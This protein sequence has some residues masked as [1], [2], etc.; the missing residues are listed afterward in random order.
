MVNGLHPMEIATNAEVRNQFINLYNEIWKNEMGEA[1]YENEVLFFQE[2]IANTISQI[3]SSIL[4]SNRQKTDAQAYEEAIAKIDRFSVYVAFR[5]ICFTDLS[6]EPGANALAYIMS[7]IYKAIGANGNLQWKYRII[8]CVSGYGELIARK[9]AGQIKYVDNPVVVYANDEFRVID[10]NGK[11]SI[12][13]SMVLPHDG[14]EIIACYM[15]ITRGDDS[16]DYSVLTKEDW[17]RLLMFSDKQNRSKDDKRALGEAANAL[18]TSNGGQIDKG[19][20]IA[21]CVKHGFKLF[22][23][24][25]IGRNAIMG[26]DNEIAENII[27]NSDEVIEPWND[28][29]TTCQPK[30]TVVSGN[31]GVQVT[32]DNDIF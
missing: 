32:D 13:Y 19:F 22:E 29:D 28:G 15:R 8:Y 16:V 4:K 27:N 12:R 24:V 31:A 26:G 21:K 5:E 25:R 10:E 1:V 9:R 11:K 20:L 23:R 14:K 2:A 3:Q 7:R 18:Y 17:M 30:V 6:L